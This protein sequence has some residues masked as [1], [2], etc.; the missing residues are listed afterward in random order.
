MRSAIHATDSTCSGCTANTAAVKADAPVARVIR[1]S[2]RKS[3][4]AA[5]A[6]WSTFTAWKPAGSKPNS[7]RSRCSESQVS[8][9]Q[10]ASYGSRNARHT[11]AGETF[12]WRFG[13]SVT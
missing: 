5:N 13:L 1:W 2:A 11:A 3:S 10:F 4:T 8:G 12:S 9:I 7:V 6:C